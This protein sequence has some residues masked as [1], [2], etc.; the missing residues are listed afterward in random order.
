MIRYNK[1]NPLDVPLVSTESIKLESG[2][3]ELLRVN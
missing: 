1:I 2:P 3:E